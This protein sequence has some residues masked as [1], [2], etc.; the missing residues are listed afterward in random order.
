MLED[1]PDETSAQDQQLK[2]AA[3]EMLLKDADARLEISSESSSQAAF[4]AIVMVAIIVMTFVFNLGHWMPAPAIWMARVVC[5]WVAIVAF[6]LF[7]I[8][9]S[10]ERSARRA[11]ATIK[12]NFSN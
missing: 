2:R 1:T 9:K 7:L 6:C 10:D 11:I 4:V 5:G 3:A 12:Q 8:S